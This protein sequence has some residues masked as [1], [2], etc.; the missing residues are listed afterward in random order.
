[1]DFGN[2]QRWSNFSA[3]RIK[4]AWLISDDNNKHLASAV[5]HRFLHCE[6]T[7]PHLPCS[8]FWKQVIMQSPHWGGWG[9]IRI[10]LYFLEWG[11]S[12]RCVWNAFVK[13]SCHFPYFFPPYIS[14]FISCLLSWPKNPF[15]FFHKMLQK[16]LNELS[17]QPSI[18]SLCQ[19]ILEQ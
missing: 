3:D 17:D 10:N 12:K 15:E 6:V 5:F 8:T 7:S 13:K 11:M 18:Y 1:M 16:N 4:G 14:I 9:E 2:M 19:N